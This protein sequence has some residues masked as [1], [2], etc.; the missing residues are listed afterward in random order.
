MELKKQYNTLLARHHKAIKFLDDPDINLDKKEVFIGLYR[1]VL[2]KLNETV[3]ELQR[4]GVEFTDKEVL[5]GFII[6]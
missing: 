5:E 6:D 2:K 4:S 1:E 3:K